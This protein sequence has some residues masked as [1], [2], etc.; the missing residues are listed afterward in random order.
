MY[1]GYSINRLICSD[2]WATNSYNRYIENSMLSILACY[3]FNLSFVGMYT[4][5]HF[6]TWYAWYLSF[7]HVVCMV[8]ILSVVYVVSI[9]SVVCVVSI[10]YVVCHGKILSLCAIYGVITEQ[11]IVTIY[12]SLHASCNDLVLD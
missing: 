1:I 6:C 8:S 10:L 5:Y 2:N 9:L 12:L 3:P 11:Q 7:L 4:I